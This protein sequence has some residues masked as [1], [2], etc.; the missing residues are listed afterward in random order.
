MYAQVLVGLVSSDVWTVDLLAK[1]PD[2]ADEE[3]K[4]HLVGE[5]IFHI[6]KHVEDYTHISERSYESHRCGRRKESE[7]RLMEWP[8]RTKAFLN[9]S[10]GL[11]QPGGH[12][13]E[14][15]EYR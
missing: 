2:D 11:S 6:V 12:F 7:L 8:C 1:N 15:G 13:S 14:L 10:F 4:V 9:S 3:N 5:E